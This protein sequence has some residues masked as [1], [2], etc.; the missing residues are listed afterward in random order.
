RGMSHEAVQS[1][2]ESLQIGGEQYKGRSDAHNRLGHELLALGL[3]Q[4][5]ADVVSE[6]A[7][8]YRAAVEAASAPL[9]RATI[10]TN[11]GTCLVHWW[12]FD[13]NSH[14][15][16]ESVEVYQRAL[17]AFGRSRERV[18][19]LWPSTQRDLGS[20]LLLLAKHHGRYDAATG[21]VN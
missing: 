11:L 20:A 12:T 10:Q 9:V 2:R 21:A 1:Y 15:L 13:H 14:H 8:S 6:A 7:A 18:K 16:D 3:A 5:N 4:K 17:H 19:Q